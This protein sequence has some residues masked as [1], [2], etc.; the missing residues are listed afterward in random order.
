MTPSSL[1]YDVYLLCLSHTDY[2]SS[3][4][5]IS[6]VEFYLQYAPSTI[7][8][9]VHPS[10]VPLLCPPPPTYITTTP[11][12]LTPHLGDES[13]QRLKNHAQI[14]YFSYGV[15]DFALYLPEKIV[16]QK[17]V[18]LLRYKNRFESLVQSLVMKGI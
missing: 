6:P 1:T 17:K 14:E 5:K 3:L 12:S 10:Y 9:L 13:Y 15:E 11:F 16:P 8:L 7:S 2:H 18:L 4:T